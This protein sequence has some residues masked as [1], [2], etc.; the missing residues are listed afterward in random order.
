MVKNEKQYLK[1]L[2]KEIYINL[3]DESFSPPFSLVNKLYSPHVVNS[4]G[5][6][7][8]F[9]NFRG[10]QCSMEL[11]LDQFTAHQNRK[12]YYVIFSKKPDGIKRL[13][14]LSKPF[15]GKHILFKLSDW[16]GEETIPQLAKPLKI[17]DFGRPVLEQYPKNNEFFYGV[18]V[19]EKL[20]LQRNETKR[21]ISRVVEFTRTINE[22]LA[23]EKARQEAEDYKA[24]E[25]RKAV[26]RHL[27]R[28]R[29][30]H[31]ATLRKQLDNYICHV[32]GYDYSKVYGSLGE[33]FAEAHHIIPL[34]RDNEQRTTTIEDLITVC[35]NCHRMLH[36]MKGKSEDIKNLKKIIRK[37]KTSS[38]SK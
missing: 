38:K 20:G 4:G 28:E 8:S 32:C 29:R 15:L 35:A 2:A 22:A 14:K 34:G 1:N 10:Y 31:L 30:S 18:Y 36:R 17:K 19:F 37:R 25:N 3:K 33:D 12:L 23:Q 26:Q 6:A 9:G 21:L 13:V 16:S 24:I 7:I 5:W 11:W 27:L